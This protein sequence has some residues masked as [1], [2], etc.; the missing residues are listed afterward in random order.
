MNTE[1]V[2]IKQ[3]KPLPLDSLQPLPKVNQGKEWEKGQYWNTLLT[4]DLSSV[5]DALRQKAGA[6]DESLPQEERDYRLM[7]NINRSWVVDYQNMSREQVRSAWP[8]L[9]RDL[10]RLFGVGNSEKELYSALSLKNADAPKAE[11]ARRLYRE[12]YLSALRGEMPDLPDEEADFQI[13]DMAQGHAESLRE[14]YM[15]LA[16]SI[17]EAWSAIKTMESNPVYTPTVFA[18]V[19][20]LVRAVDE[21]ADMDADERARVYAIARSL[22]STRQLEEKPDN[23]AEAMLHSVR[24]GAAD[25]G[26][27]ALQGLGHV[28]TALT[29]AAGETLESDT[30]RNLSSAADKRLQMLDE[31]RRV[32]Q[33]E[34]FP[35]DLGE[36][37]N[38]AEQMAVDAAGAVPGAIAAFSG[39]AGFG[40]L[41][42]S[43]TGAAVAEARRRSPKGRQELQ[44]AAGILGG[45]LQAS[46]YAGMSRIGAQ[47]LNR[48]INEFMRAGSAGWKGYSL[49][50]LK[51][52]GILTAENAKMLLAG[53]AAQAAE[54]GTQELAARVDKVASN[55]DWETFGNNFTDIE[56]NMREAAMNLPFVLIAAGRAALHHFRSPS[57]LLDNGGRLS[58]WGVDE[59]TRLRIIEEPDIHVQNQLLREALCSSRRWSGAGAVE[60]LMRSLLLLNTEYHAGFK[61]PRARVDFLNKKSSVEGL[62]RPET[63]VRDTG[64][65]EEMLQVAERLTGRK[66]MPL[67]A[68]KSLPY[69]L[70]MDE[71]YQKGN[72]SVVK[73]KKQQ[74]ERFG[75]YHKMLSDGASLLPKQ[76]KLNGIYN[77]HREKAIQMLMADRVSEMINLSY[78][79]LL[80]L[81][82]LDSL[83]GSYFNIDAARQK[84]EARRQRIC[85]ELCSAIHRAASGVPREEAFET[86]YNSIEEMYRE[87]RRSAAYAPRWFR[88]VKI[89]DF[90]DTYGKAYRK[91]SRG[92]WN[93]QPELLEAYRIMLG[94][95][96]CGES[97][98]DILPHT[99]DFQTFLTQGM[100]PE[101][102]YKQILRRELGDHL[103]PKVW[104]PELPGKNQVDDG[105]NR[106]RLNANMPIM[107]RFLALTDYKFEHTS[108]GKGGKL[109]RLKGP[110]G[111]YT[112]WFAE[113]M[114]LVNSVVGN[115]ETSFLRFSKNALEEEMARGIWKDPA[116][117]RSYYWRRRAF[118][119]SDTE[120]T[121]F[122]H[123]GSTAAR[124]LCTQWLGDST[125]FGVGLEFAQDNKNWVRH[126]GR[127]LNGDMKVLHEDTNRYLV[128]YRHPMTPLSLVRYRCFAYWNRL[129]TSGWVTPD[130]VGDLLV[131]EHLLS[132]AELQRVLE[133]GR[134]RFRNILHMTGAYRREFVKKYP[135]HHIPGDPV[136]MHSTLASHMADLNV[137]HLLAN[138]NEAQ[139]PDSVKQ[140]FRTTPFSNVIP[141]EIPETRHEVVMKA[142]RAAAEEVK[143]MI[144]QVADLRKRMKQGE[145]LPLDW[146]LRNAYEPNEDRRHEQGWCY[147]FGGEQTFRSAGQPFWNL[148]DDPVKAWKLLGE[149]EQAELVAELGQFSEG[150]PF[151]QALQDLGDVLKQYPGIRAYGLEQRNSTT[152]SR[153]V[154]EPIKMV[155]VATPDY[156]K[157]RNSM[158]YV[159]DFVQKGYTMEKNV[160]LPV[161]C[162]GDARVLPALRLLSEIRRSITNVAYMD[163]QGIWWKQERY[164]G[165]DGKMPKNM[166]KGWEPECGLQSFLNYYNRVAELGDAYG[167]EGMLNVCGV[168]MGGIRPGEL[169]MTRLQHVTVYRSSRMPEHMVRLMPGLP[170]AANPRQRSPYV[171]HSADGIPLFAKRMARYVPENEKA[172]TPLP[173]F[174]SDM[175][176]MYDYATNRRWRERLMMNYMND[177]VRKRAISA[178]SWAEHDQR[179]VNNEEMFMQIFQDSRLSYFL[180]TKDP[181]K[182]TRGEALTSELA[183][184]VI[185]AEY[186]LNRQEHVSNLVKFCAKLRGEWED[187]ALI[188]AVLNRVVSPE[189]NRYAEHEK[190]RSEEDRKLDLS[191]ED[192][193][194]Y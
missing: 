27:S 182:L 97:L 36:E 99:K 103:D 188:R 57:K 191:P 101:E 105:D 149:K 122:D 44:T 127:R 162:R 165:T 8:E 19:P 35:I 171:V 160:E 69:L 184:L 5:P 121:G 132:P 193:E 89:E 86:F 152:L 80:N 153:M 26:H 123:L 187:S 47:M 169:D 157:R 110:D 173:Q 128:R 18:K 43:G 58:E 185:L 136:A 104:K 23:L 126:H 118:K 120:Y 1:T 194:Y 15:P 20:G 65:Q 79:A 189:P 106:Y 102:A 137:L 178:Q 172:L 62:S 109:W 82:S 156:T 67:N 124:D 31:L 38:L 131:K 92:R 32:A 53:K 48:T 7:T 135:D 72:G 93:G 85:S 142:N 90:R 30:L 180:E 116:S 177:L 176:R 140:W 96:A 158:S 21:L 159:P 138:L 129:L 175:E 56:A 119:H 40:L 75:M 46:I 88:K 66:S 3:D 41:T 167:T 143:Q 74:V 151:E 9:R 139:L 11:K 14:Q 64:N 147:A 76:V 111:Q 91:A 174:N 112:D 190:P 68:E 117:H 179:A 130:E 144:P 78:Q 183:R 81:E 70:L 10:T 34:L 37:S 95:R 13:S 16:E 39:G 59:P 6:A 155:D 115:V 100:T 54:L 164:G 55:I 166:G 77:P 49:A 141:P 52:L 51:G 4:G 168:P 22:D 50:A 42:L 29:R 108:D 192:A 150:K 17:S 24:R 161:E 63:V 28:A 33:G 186:G 133:S 2:E 114:H 73:D 163:E 60:E 154:L 83:K 25:L 71:W 98:M 61:D 145:K 12:H 45:A 134:P 125:L 113:P 181:T 107:H 84:T 94:L 148:L 146:Y 170:D 87:R